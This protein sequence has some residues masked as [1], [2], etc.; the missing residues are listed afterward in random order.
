[1]ADILRVILR[2]T[3][4]NNEQEAEHII[5]NAL[6]KCMHATRCAVN[7]AMKTSPGALT[8]GRDM[9]MDVPLIANLSA[10]RESR[11]QLI[12]KN[13]VRMNSKRIKTGSNPRWRIYPCF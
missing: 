7:H 9:L 8:F 13:L 11:Q 3:E 12:D 1:M 10:I 2:T 4:A 6:A 5:D